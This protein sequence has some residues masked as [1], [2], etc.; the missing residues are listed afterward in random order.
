MGG[1]ERLK[2]SDEALQLA[3]CVSS[4][5]GGAG[6]LHRWHDAQV[7]ARAHPPPPFA[8]PHRVGGVAPAIRYDQRSARGPG[9]SHSAVGH[10]SRCPKEINHDATP[11]AVEVAGKDQAPTIPQQAH[12]PGYV[13]GG[14]YPKTLAATQLAHEVKHPVV[15]HALDE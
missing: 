5:V 4:R 11:C 14:Y 15:L 6:R 8:R 7:V 10:T 2:Y 1:D 9:Q 12:Y 13:C 3:A